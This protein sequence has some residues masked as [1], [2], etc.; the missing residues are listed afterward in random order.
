MS[1]RGGRWLPVT[2]LAVAV[3]ALL[4]SVLWAAGAWTP[5]SWRA[6]TAGPGYG[7]MMGVAEPG[8]GPVRDLDDAERT[9]RRFADGWGLRVGEVMQ[10][11]N[12]FYAE[13]VDPSGSGATEVLID[14][15]TGS[16][17]LEF[18]PAMMW[19]ARYGMMRP[20]A[21]TGGDRIGP[22]E[23]RRIAEKWLRT[24]APG[25]SADEAEAFPGYYT[26]HTMSGDRIAGMLSVHATTGAVWYHTWHGRFI[27]IR[28]VRHD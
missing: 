19:N 18:G 26:L 12:G 15:A 5:A 23:A 8:T 22:A 2:V 25:L 21:R 20:G 27:A 16:V 28:E 9:A 7:P 1:S 4:G 3:V 6:G 14:P 13:L 24:N 10:F 11:D 17:R